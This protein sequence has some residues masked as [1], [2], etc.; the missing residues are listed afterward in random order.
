MNLKKAKLLRKEVGYKPGPAQTHPK[1]QGYLK[2]KTWDTIIV[3]PKSP[4]GQYR[5]L[6]KAA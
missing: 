6:K 2:N 5:A 1:G 3:D 4:R